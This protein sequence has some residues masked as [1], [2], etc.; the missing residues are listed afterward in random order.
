MLQHPKKT[1]LDWAKFHWDK[2]K[3]EANRFWKHTAFATVALLS[4]SM[5]QLDVLQFNFSF[6]KVSL[7]ANNLALKRWLMC[8]VSAWL[9]LSI[10]FG[11]VDFL[12]HRVPERFEH[13][14]HNNSY[15]V[16]WHTSNIDLKKL[17]RRLYF[18]VILVYLAILGCWVVYCSYKV[19]A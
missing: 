16:P 7:A 9:W 14:I 1:E 13:F 18:I 11:L 19:W 12:R 17:G 4:I 10:L 6:L 2:W 3:D 8:P 5:Y 15:P